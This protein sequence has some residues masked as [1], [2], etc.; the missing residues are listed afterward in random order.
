[1]VQPSKERAQPCNLLPFR[2]TETKAQMWT[3]PSSRETSR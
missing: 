3:C 1:M 2:V